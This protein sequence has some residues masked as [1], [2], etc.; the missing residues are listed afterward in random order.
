VLLD[1]LQ[2]RLLT[3]QQTCRDVNEAVTQQYFH[4][5]PYVAWA[6]VRASAEEAH[7]I[8]ESEL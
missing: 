5:S 1:E 2:D 3:L 6:D 7:F 8:E 4:V